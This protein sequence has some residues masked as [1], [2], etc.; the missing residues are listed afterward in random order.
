MLREGGG[1][2]LNTKDLHKRRKCHIIFNA[3]SCLLT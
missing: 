2:I 1:H 3:A